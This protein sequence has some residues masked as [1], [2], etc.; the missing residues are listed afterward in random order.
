MNMDSYKLN[1]CNVKLL[2]ESFDESELWYVND[3]FVA[4]V[5]KARLPMT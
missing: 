3:I 4:R 2:S 1:F 5:C